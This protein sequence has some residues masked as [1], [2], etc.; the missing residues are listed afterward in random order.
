MDPTWE[1]ARSPAG[2]VRTTA[3]KLVA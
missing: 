2:S 1:E 3:P